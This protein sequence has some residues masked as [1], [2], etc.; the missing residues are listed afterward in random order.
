MQTHEL[1]TKVVPASITRA[2][3]R[4]GGARA[5][6]AA[7]GR[8]GARGREEGKEGEREKEKRD[9]RRRS[10]RAVRKKRGGFGRRLKSDD[11]T[12][13]KLGGD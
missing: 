7:K 5:A 3:A 8:S 9:S 13:E 1:K 4:G 10:R 11:R 2:R 12:A 6:L